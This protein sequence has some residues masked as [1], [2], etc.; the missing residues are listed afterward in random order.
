MNNPKK[1]K[2][3]IAVLSATVFLYLVFILLHIFDPSSGVLLKSKDIN[4]IK[5]S[6]TSESSDANN[7]SLVSVQG[8]EKFTL[9]SFKDVRY[10]GNKN[11]F[12]VIYDNKNNKLITNVESNNNFVSIIDASIVQHV[13][14]N[15]FVIVDSIGDIYSIDFSSDKV[16]LNLI[17]TSDITKDTIFKSIY[18]EDTLYVITRQ[19]LSKYNEMTLNDNTVHIIEFNKKYSKAIVNPIFYDNSF[20]YSFVLNNKGDIGIVG[21]SYIELDGEEVNLY[22]L[23]GDNEYLSQSATE[24]NNYKLIDSSTIWMQFFNDST[25]I[26][27]TEPTL[28][29]SY[30]LIS[31]TLETKFGV[32]ISVPQNIPLV[33]GDNYSIYSTYKYNTILYDPAILPSASVLKFEGNEPLESD[34]SIRSDIFKYNYKNYIAFFNSNEGLIG[35]NKDGSMEIITNSLISYLNKNVILYMKNGN[36]YFKK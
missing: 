4:S 22:K 20:I 14:D 10:S 34:V 19:Y 21:S 27:L 35:V 12:Y 33:I 24:N 23:P 11:T 3:V 32:D 18:S 28:N 25:K 36:L 7:L 5:H 17:G 9:L 1:F 6:I 16:K 31:H 8:N 15:L 26:N 30:L 13:K 2:V 29:L